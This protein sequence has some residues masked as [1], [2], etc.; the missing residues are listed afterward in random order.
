VAVGFYFHVGFVASM[1]KV[2]Q[3]RTAFDIR[4]GKGIGP[5]SLGMTRAQ[6]REIAERE[7]GADVIATA[8]ADAV[9][10]SGIAILYDKDNRCRRVSVS[11]DSFPVRYAFTLFG[12]DICGATDEFVVRLCKTHWPH[13]YDEDLG[14]GLS[15][16]TA[17]FWAEYR[18]DHRDG[19]YQR[20]IVARAD[21]RARLVGLMSS[22]GRAIGYVI[23]PTLF[24]TLFL[25][26]AVAALDV[27]AFDPLMAAIFLSSSWLGWWLLGKWLIERDF[28][29]TI[30]SASVNLVLTFL[31]VGSIVSGARQLQVSETWANTLVLTWLVLT[32]A[33][34]VRIIWKAWRTMTRVAD[35]S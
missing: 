31:A 3:P 12:E 19:K 6:V 10:D 27:K 29:A 11:F 28:V 18:E 20:V 14:W 13:I 34:L 30:V 2:E 4:A 7:L 32:L 9:G 1:S 24:A 33:W 17:G 21:W 8:T 25:A 35:R 16:P 5:F 15:V 26:V 23:V 22:I